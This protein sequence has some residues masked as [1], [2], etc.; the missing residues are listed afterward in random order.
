MGFCQA[1]AGGPLEHSCVEPMRGVRLP[2][3]EEGVLEAGV[4]RPLQGVLALADQ[5]GVPATLDRVV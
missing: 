4:R 2:V 1:T 3:D 5:H